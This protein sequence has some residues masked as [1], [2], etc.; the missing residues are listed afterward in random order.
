MNIKFR[1]MKCNLTITIAGLILFS[2]CSNNTTTV[3][4]DD[5]LS[6]L[7]PDSLA[8]NIK[9]LSSDAFEGRKPFTAGE[10]KTVEFL[11]QQFQNIGLEPGNGTSFY[12]DVPM[13][14][15]TTQ[16]VPQMQVFS[17]RGNFELKGPEEYVI[18]T[19]KTDPSVALDHTEI[20]FA[21][22]GVVAPE[23]NWNDYE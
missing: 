21:G 19:D 13:V 17:P 3:G 5:G 14:R 15:I 1:G 16:A 11:K 8:N 22:Y 4:E 9:I 20:V 12:Q 7:N 10:T 18:W 6:V 2:S 23:H